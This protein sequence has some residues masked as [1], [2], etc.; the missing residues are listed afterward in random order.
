MG[1]GTGQVT[2]RANRGNKVWMVSHR[3]RKSPTNIEGWSLKGCLYS[4]G[5]FCESAQVFCNSA[6][7]CFCE[8]SQGKVYESAQSKGYER[9][10]PKAAKTAKSNNWEP[11]YEE[12]PITVGEAEKAMENL[13]NTISD[14]LFG[15]SNNYEPLIAATNYTT[16][17]ATF[18]WVKGDENFDVELVSVIETE[19]IAAVT[20]DIAIDPDISGNYVIAAFL[21]YNTLILVSFEGELS[22]DRSTE[23]HVSVMVIG[24]NL[25]E[26]CSYEVDFLLDLRGPSVADEFLGVSF[27]LPDLLRLWHLKIAAFVTTCQVSALSTAT[28]VII[29]ATAI[30]IN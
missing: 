1:A 11:E 16:S 5:S 8:S 22:S 21:E 19:S 24:L 23:A 18:G 30:N 29:A 27:N 9:S 25:S 14:S 15:L 13:S 7:G 3:V 20:A 2:V 12:E 6:Q 10:A 4:Q 28:A 26:G 17:G